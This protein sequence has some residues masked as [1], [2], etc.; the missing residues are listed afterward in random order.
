MDS[1]N[2]FKF[3]G[4]QKVP[5]FFNVSHNGGVSIII[6]GSQITIKTV[7]FI[8]R[9]F[10]IYDVKEV[11]YGKTCFG[12]PFVGLKINHNGK[13]LIHLFTVS[14]NLSTLKLETLDK[15]LLEFKNKIPIRKV[16]DKIITGK[17]LRKYLNN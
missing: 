2:I 5:G 12:I 16:D 9:K 15:F 4:Y 14:L 13:E 11:L 1:K 10:S 8:K 6:N 7:F 3:N 17:S